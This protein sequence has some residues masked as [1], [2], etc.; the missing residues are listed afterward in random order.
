MVPPGPPPPA[1]RYNQHPSPALQSH[2][3]FVSNPAGG[4]LPPQPHQV[5]LGQH[6]AHPKQ[7]IIIHGTFLFFA[8]LLYNSLCLSASQSVCNAM[9]E[10][11]DL[12]FEVKHCGHRC[13]SKFAGD[14]DV[15]NLY[16]HGN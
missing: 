6:H 4:M 16:M 10:S 14:L 15:Q 8:K 13:H 5:S 9:A 1:S 3:G 2:Q 7:D 11:L 12:K